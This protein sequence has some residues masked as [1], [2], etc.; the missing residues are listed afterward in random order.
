MKTPMVMAHA[1]GSPAQE[2][3]LAELERGLAA[4][5]D[6]LRERNA[7]RIEAATHDLHHALAMAAPPLARSAREHPVSPALQ[8]RLMRASAQVAAQ[9]D[10]VARA[11]ASVDRALHV[12][13]PAPAA[14]TYAAGGVAERPP[15]S[16]S[17]MA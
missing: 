14:T 7:S 17:S 8:Q 9:R 4:L 15:H 1:D 13:L 3:Q 11:C 10:A 6:A 5:S 16:G 12:L 2:Q